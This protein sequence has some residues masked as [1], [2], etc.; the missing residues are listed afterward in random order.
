MTSNKKEFI[1]INTKRFD[2]L[3]AAAPSAFSTKNNDAIENFLTALK[4]LND[5]YEA[6]V[7]KKMDQTYHVCNQDEDF[8]GDV[9]NIMVTNAPEEVDEEPTNVKT[10][11]H[12]RID[13]DE[14]AKELMENLKNT[15]KVLIDIIKNIRGILSCPSSDLKAVII[16][17]NTQVLKLESVIG[18][19]T[20]TLGSLS[21]KD[22]IECINIDTYETGEGILLDKVNEIINEVNELIN[23]TGDIKEFKKGMVEKLNEIIGRVNEK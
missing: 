17:I 15:Q 11:I 13:K 5:T 22:G 19:D 23:K 6:K 8:A 21:Q 10:P 18:L 14:V 1:V 16:L 2:E 20:G 9:L 7:G 12:T 4:R 3:N